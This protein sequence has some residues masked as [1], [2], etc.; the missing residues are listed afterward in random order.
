MKVSPS[1][2]AKTATIL[3]QETPRRGIVVRQLFAFHSLRPL[4]AIPAHEEFLKVLEI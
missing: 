3:L 2:Q 4:G 1:Q